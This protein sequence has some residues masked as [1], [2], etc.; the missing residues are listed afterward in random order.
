MILHVGGQSLFISP[1]IDFVRDNFANETHF[2]W[3]NGSSK[4]GR[5]FRNDDVYVAERSVLGYLKAY[6]ALVIYLQRSRKVILHGLFDIRTLLILFAF[7]WLIKKC[8]WIMWGGDLYA[9]RRR[10][11]SVR[12][13]LC[14]LIRS[15]VIK[16]IRHVCTYIYGD[17]ELLC[18]WYGYRGELH[19]CLMYLSNVCDQRDI[20][21]PKSFDNKTSLDAIRV[22]VGNSATVTNNHFESIKKLHSV[23]R[24]KKIEVVIPLSYGDKEYAEEVRKN[25]YSVFPCNVEVLTE[26]KS[27]E[28]YE[29]ILGSI[30]IVIFNHDRQQAMGNT[31]KLLS[32]GK[33]VYLRNDVPQFKLFKDYGIKVFDIENIVLT[34]L[35]SNTMKQNV[36]IMHSEFSRDKLVSQYEKIFQ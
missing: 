33:K 2:F 14:E 22:L 25:A 28:E 18:R 27:K 20:D 15:V 21:V 30:D 29:H 3:L 32:L 13:K 8:Y 23:S 17:Y 10:N 12:N 19:P 31:I 36:R 16:R 6:L 35:D 1:F 9:Y 26:L 4:N 11:D 34:R 24:G 7:P 5:V